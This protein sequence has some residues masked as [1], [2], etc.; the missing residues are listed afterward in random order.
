[1]A[2]KTGEVGLGLVGADLL[3]ARAGFRLTSPIQS[4]KCGLRAVEYASRTA[5]DKEDTEGNVRLSPFPR[6][7]LCG[8]M[9]YSDHG[10]RNFSIAAFRRGLCPWG[11]GRGCDGFGAGDYFGGEHAGET[12]GN[13]GRIDAALVAAAGPFGAGRD[14][15]G[16]GGGEEH[17]H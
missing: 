14:H 7:A 15:G 1:M 11:E 9:R 3:N 12:W 10:F 6:G 8:R 17:V 5:E 16:A 2:E 13:G 4:T